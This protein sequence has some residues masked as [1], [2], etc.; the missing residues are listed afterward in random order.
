ML[1]NLDTVYPNF[2]AAHLHGFSKMYAYFWKKYKW[3][4]WKGNIQDIFIDKL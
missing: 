4:R 1:F 3:N 2:Y